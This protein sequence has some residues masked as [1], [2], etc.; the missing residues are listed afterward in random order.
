MNTRIS[1]SPRLF[2]VIT[3]VLS[4]TALTRA[5]ESGLPVSTASAEMDAGAQLSQ[6]QLDDLLG[7]IALYPDALIALILPASTAPAEIVLAARFISANGDPSQIDGQPWSDSVKAL[8]RY[9][10][11]IT[12]MDTN[13]QWTKEV[14]D[15]FIAQPSDLMN[16]VQRL[17]SIAKANGALV[18]TPQQ[19]VI[20]EDNEI[21]ILPAQPDVIY[22]PRYD[23]EIV[24]VDRPYGYY[25]S[26][27]F[28]TF[29]PAFAAG[30]WLNYDFDWRRRTIWVGDR[31]HDWREHYDW[32]SR[33][34]SGGSYPPNANWH[35][36]HAPTNRPAPPRNYNR[37][38]PG[39]FHPRPFPGTPN[40]P[41]PPRPSRPGD[42]G[43]PNNAR[44]N[45]RPGRPDNSN[46]RDNTPPP[47][48]T[49]NR[50]TPIEQ[51]RATPATPSRATPAPAE[52][53]PVTPGPPHRP[54]PDRGGT[55]PQVDRR[56][57]PPG[58]RV[59]TPPAERRSAPPVER[60]APP[61]ADRRG[62]PTPDR[63]VAAPMPVPQNRSPGPPQ[64]RHIN[65]APVQPRIAPAPPAPPAPKVQPERVRDRDPKD[66]EN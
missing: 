50:A 2:L 39:V 22:I 5:A 48:S 31:R 27:P 43:P 64:D 7:P 47:A 23:P 61:Q 58:E 9:P 41:R 36:W 35:A 53:P 28:I 20:V 37:P 8:A 29:G 46:R 6:A 54:Q 51:N 44:D 49:Y 3:S 25:Y 10:E 62:S 15:A 65:P 33:Q 14:G 32:R 18:T 55:P 13:L 21:E 34:A 59:V 56:S 26:D 17:R 40:I 4:S 1:F 52:R 24:Y 38:D 57:N 19:K 60:V 42:V 45:S 11:V 30:I 16:A 66:R 12:W 63:V